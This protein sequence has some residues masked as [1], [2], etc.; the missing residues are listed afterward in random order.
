MKLP[1]RVYRAEIRRAL[2]YSEEWFRLLQKRGLIP[3]GRRDYPNGR[4]WFTES[5]ARAIIK[6]RNAAAVRGKGRAK[7]MAEAT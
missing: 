3:Q 1:C 2:G 4:E 5:E 7:Q 6:K